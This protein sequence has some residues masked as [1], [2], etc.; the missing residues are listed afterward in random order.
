L[1]ATGVDPEGACQNIFKSL[2]LQGL[3]DGEDVTFPAFE[4]QALPYHT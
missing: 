1:L 4:G 2:I 3:D